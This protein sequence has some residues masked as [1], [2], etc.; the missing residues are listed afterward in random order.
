[1]ISDLPGPSIKPPGE[2]NEDPGPSERDQ[3]VT[4]LS[5][6]Q[7]SASASSS[8]EV[9]SSS[10]DEDPSTIAEIPKKRLKKDP[11]GTQDLQPF[12]ALVLNFDGSEQFY[13]DKKSERGYLRVEALH[14]PACPSYYSSRG[15]LGEFSRNNNKKKKKKKGSFKRYFSR[16]FQKRFAEPQGSRDGTTVPNPIAANADEFL[17]ANKLLN[18]STMDNVKNVSAWIDLVQYQDQTPMKQVSRTQLAERKFD[19][20]DKALVHNPTSDELYSL[21]VTIANQVLPSYEV[22]KVV[23]KL[24]TKD[25]TNY[26]LWRGLI[27]ATQGSMARCIVPDVMQLYER[28]MQ[29][30]YRKRRCDQTMLSECGI[31]LIFFFECFGDK[32]YRHVSQCA[33]EIQNFYNTYEVS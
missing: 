10:E 30:N 5:R 27:L 11:K 2:D 25:P 12:P 7:D 33:L 19:I 3:S 16:K 13:V 8:M 24:L 4:D 18:R 26:V 31:I 28:A 29:Q 32:N 20:L 9:D 1:M 22:S 21:Y 14:R 17:E 6:H 23:E 15:G